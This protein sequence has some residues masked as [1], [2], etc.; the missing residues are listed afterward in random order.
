MLKAIG[1]TKYLKHKNTVKYLNGSLRL[2]MNDVILSKEKKQEF[3]SEKNLGKLQKVI[4]QARNILAVYTWISKDIERMYKLN[5]QKIYPPT[6]K[7]ES[8]SGSTTGRREHNLTFK[9]PA[10]HQG[11]FHY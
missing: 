10:Y 5:H 11:A 1:A 8:K 4:K 2:Q 9:E 3:L 6:R 7:G